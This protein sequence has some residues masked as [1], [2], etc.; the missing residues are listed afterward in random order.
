MFLSRSGYFDSS[1]APDPPP[2][3]PPR[4][5]PLPA[6]HLSV[7]SELQDPHPSAPSAQEASPS[8]VLD[9]RPV[10]NELLVPRI[11][12]AQSRYSAWGWRAF[13]AALLMGSLPVALLVGL[14]VALLV[15]L[16]SLGTNQGIF[17]HQRRV[18]LDGEVF[19]LFKFRTMN[20]PVRRPSGNLDSWAEGDEGRTTRIGKFLRKS[21]LDEVP[22][23]INVL[24]GEMAVIGPRPEMVEVSDWVEQRLPLFSARLGILPGITGWAQVEQGYCGKDVAGYQRKLDLDLEYTRDRSLA[25]DVKIIAKTSRIMLAM[26]GWGIK[27]ASIT[28]VD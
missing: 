8:P 18:G 21:H 5:P 1:R 23:L 15:K 17:F 26:K 4:L 2:P 12:P 11:L 22:Q 24:K 16:E 9:E 25:L 14:P 27:R 7:R 20:A 10:F 3:I 13:N 28:K 19:T 6:S